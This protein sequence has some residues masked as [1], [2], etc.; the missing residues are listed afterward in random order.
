MNKRKQSS[1][2]KSRRYSKK[3][4]KGTERWEQGAIWTQTRMIPELKYF[5][6]T[7]ASLNILL[8]GSSGGTVISGMFVPVLGSDFINRIG[9]K[10]QIQS[11]RVKGYYWP[12]NITTVVELPCQLS[13]LL[14]LDR[15]ADGISAPNLGDIIAGTNGSI[16]PTGTSFRQPNTRKRY[17][18]LRQLDTYTP[19][20]AF[21][22]QTGVGFGTALNTG[23][24]TLNTTFALCNDSMRFDYY[25]DAHKAKIGAT[26]FNASSTGA[27]SDIEANALLMFLYAGVPTSQT[28]N[29]SWNVSMT[30]RVAYTDC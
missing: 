25:I 27:Y 2:G 8:A 6:F 19:Q 14:I 3:V 18:I 21:I 1:Y 9:R 10:V 4:K 23:T 5:D 7:S 16:S 22:T 20:C 28:Y 26:I 17:K 13:Q 12:Y 11:I 30:S 29:A 15:N 24:G